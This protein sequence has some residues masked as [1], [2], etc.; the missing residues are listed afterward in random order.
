MAKPKVYIIENKGYKKDRYLYRVKHINKYGT[1]LVSLAK[2]KRE[3]L[4]I[5]RQI[6]I[7]WLASETNKEEKRRR[8]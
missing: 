3:A 1:Q 6:L 7:D 2:N 5:K 4:S 8:D